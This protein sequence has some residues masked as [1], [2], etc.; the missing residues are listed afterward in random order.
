MLSK[1][2]INTKING[3]VRSIRT[4]KHLEK[5]KTINN[6][7]HQKVDYIH[8]LEVLNDKDK[9][10]YELKETHLESIDTNYGL[11]NYMKNVYKY[12]GLG[13]GTTLVVG[14]AVP[15]IIG[16]IPTILPYAIPVWI[17]NICFSF[18]SLNKI[19][20]I[21][22]LVNTHKD[23][24]GKEFYTEEIDSDK[25]LWY[26][27]FSISNGITI[28][29]ALGAAMALSPTILP[30]AIIG[31]FGVFGGATM[32]ALNKKDFNAASWQA[33]LIGCVTGLI[34]ASLVQIG[35]GLA[36]NHQIF[37]IMDMGIT[38]VSLLTF[39]GLVAADTQNAIKSYYDKTLDSI[40]TS[41]ELLLDATNILL[42]LIKVLSEIMKATKD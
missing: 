9:V 27:L 25:K 23:K 14:S 30:T 4:L 6:I 8:P 2:R 24:K 1:L 28:S 36:G 16:T 42:D 41:V 7:N 32:Y 38:G 33:P 31:T 3:I 5:P 39:T 13:F 19:S 34:G 22:S 15:L 12:S 18:Y 29:P 40:N 20:K 17:G 10:N 37:H 21:R 35:F 26:N 11:R